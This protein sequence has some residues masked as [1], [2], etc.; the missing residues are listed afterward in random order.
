MI[1][2]SGAEIVLEDI[3]DSNVFSIETENRTKVVMSSKQ[4][5]RIE[6]HLYL[7]HAEGEGYLSFQPSLRSPWFK[8]SD[9][10]VQILVD[11]GII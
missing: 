4:F 10:F 3:C 11:N 5:P 8:A 7:T 2:D 6:F 9:A 1:G